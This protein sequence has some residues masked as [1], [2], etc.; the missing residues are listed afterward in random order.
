M[1]FREK[2]QQLLEVMF[3]KNTRN[4]T[5]YTNAKNM[6]TANFPEM[7]SNEYNIAISAI[8]DWLGL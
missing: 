7:T 4:W 3:S 8:C 6:I 2:V 1:T 5:D